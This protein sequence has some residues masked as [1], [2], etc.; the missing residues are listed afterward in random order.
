MIK[1]DEVSEVLKN[2]KVSDPTIKTIIDELKKRE[3]MKKTIGGSKS[4][5]EYAF[6]INSSNV[7]WPV[8]IEEGADSSKVLDQ[9]KAAIKEYNESKR[10][11]KMPIKTMGAAFDS[12]PRKHSVNQKI[13]IKAKS[14]VN[15]V[16]TDNS[17]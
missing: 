12:L 5:K 17:I 16:T 8:Q 7:G 14:P 1:I 4:K 6:I 11:L 13:W 10:G 2:Q 15:V 3:N 9:M